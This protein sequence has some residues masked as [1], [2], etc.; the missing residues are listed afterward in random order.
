MHHART[1][2][3]RMEI[4]LNQRI[5]ILLTPVLNAPSLAP[6]LCPS[7]ACAAFE[8]PERAGQAA[9]PHPPGFGTGPGRCKPSLH[10]LDSA[11]TVTIPVA[12]L[13][14]FL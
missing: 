1:D 10:R 12:C 13:L 14:Y 2:I 3:Y 8:G 4:E 9:R 5:L 6:P 11:E 7:A